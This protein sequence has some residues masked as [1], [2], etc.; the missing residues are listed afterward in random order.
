MLMSTMM[1][2]TMMMITTMIISFIPQLD[3]LLIKRTV[4]ISY[5]SKCKFN[6]RINKM[7]L[8]MYI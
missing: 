6:Q 1:M 4:C 5:K 2:T 7:I 8:I 3:A